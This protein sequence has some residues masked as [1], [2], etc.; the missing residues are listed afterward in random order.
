MS[1]G[2]KKET[3]LRQGLRL[4]K[5][6]SLPPSL[7]IL[8]HTPQLLQGSCLLRPFQTLVVKVF[9]RKKTQLLFALLTQTQRLLRGAKLGTVLQERL[10]F[11]G[12]LQ[13][14]KPF[15]GSL[16]SAQLPSR[17]HNF[18]LIRIPTPACNKFFPSYSGRVEVTTVL[19][20]YI[21]GDM[22]TW[23]STTGWTN[24]S[25]LP[26]SLMLWPKTNPLPTP[27]RLDSSCVV[28]LRRR[29]PLFR[30]NSKGWEWGKWRV[31]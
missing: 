18:S 15:W 3:D 10:P 21:F 7:L 16:L 4:I 13:K 25:L 22:L 1:K 14:K 5:V 31:G 8:S 30:T 17:T 26:L 28:L 6:F 19:Q 2:T 20:R 9:T 29:N 11:W 24:L 23:N 27:L 12:P